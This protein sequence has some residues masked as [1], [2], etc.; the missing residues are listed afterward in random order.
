MCAAP[1]KPQNRGLPRNLTTHPKGYRYK[2]PLTRKYVYFGKGA[3]RSDAIEAAE[4]LNLRFASTNRIADRVAGDADTSMRKLIALHLELLSSEDAPK[5]KADREWEL[6]KLSRELGGMDASEVN[7]HALA[8][9]L[10]RLG[11]DHVRKRYRMRL[12]ELF[13]TA[14][15][16]GWRDDNPA[17]V[18]RAYKPKTQRERLTAECFE[19][20]RAKAASWLQNAMDLAIQT[21][22]RR[23]DIVNLRWSQIV[24]D[25]LKVEQGKTGRR[26]AIHIGKEVRDV[27]QRCRDNIASPFVIHRLPE[28]ARPSRMRASHR[29]HHTQVLPEQLTRAF[30]DAVKHSG[31]PVAAGRTHPTFHELRSLGIALYR[32]AGWTE[33]QVQALAGHAGVKMTRHYME[34]HE[35]PWQPVESGL[36]LGRKRY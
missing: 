22:Q 6:G 24:G 3:T 17:C 21:L 14:V 11:S 29:E 32:Q 36:Q 7:T 28:K 1:R 35:A 25:I 26:L 16:E 4:R 12:V 18:L 34:G 31:I 15:H 13:D 5:T 23:E 27:L 10:R 30:S 33:E 9:Y 2:H 20:V 19:S 8:N